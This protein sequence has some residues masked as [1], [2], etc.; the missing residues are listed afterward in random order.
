MDDLTFLT[1]VCIS[2][3][4]AASNISIPLD[5]LKLW[6]DADDAATIT[7]G[8]GVS[9][10]TD[11]SGAGNTV[12]QATGALQPTYVDDVQNG[13][14]ILRFNGTSQYMAKTTPSSLV[15][16]AE[17]TCFCVN[18]ADDTVG[19]RVVFGCYE[20]TGNQR[21]WRVIRTN[22][23]AGRTVNI[24]S[25]GTGT[26][27]TLTVAGTNAQFT[28]TYFTVD[29]ADITLVNDGNSDT[30]VAATPSFAGT[31]ALYI[32]INDPAAEAWWDG[33]IGEIIF[34]NRVLAAGEITQVTS[35]LETKWGL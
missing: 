2:D 19:T 24:S 4:N 14:P 20:S 30:G 15:G 25:S 6:L 13:R 3:D 18:K 27:S 28:L 11:K 21:S 7:I 17:Y 23:A 33:D 26:D 29:D 32:G 16:L 9:Q 10:W 35:Y 8:T 22:S 1:T 12:V 5:G 34:Y 31:S